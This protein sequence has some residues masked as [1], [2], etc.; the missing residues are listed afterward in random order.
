MQKDFD[1]FFDQEDIAAGDDSS[2]ERISRTVHTVETSSFSMTSP[3]EM[4]TMPLS[5][6]NSFKNHESGDA[7]APSDLCKAV[8]L[9]FFL[10]GIGILLPFNVIL[11]CLDFY[12]IVVSDQIYHLT[13][14]ASLNN[15]FA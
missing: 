2:R 9:M 14:Y 3:A 7:D 12:E 11:S 15:F 4:L 5:M 10:Y 6:K 13:I 8:Y 1:N